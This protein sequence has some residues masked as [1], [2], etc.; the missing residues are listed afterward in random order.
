M[1]ILG[2][3]GAP[4]TRCNGHDALCT[5][6]YDEV[7]YA[8]THNA[9]SVK[10]T[11]AAANQT[12]TIETQLEE[13]IRGLMLDTHYDS[14]GVASYCHNVCGIGREPLVPGLEIIRRFLDKNPR[15]VVTLIFEAHISSADT[16]A[17]FEAC[18]LIRYVRRQPL[19]A[20]WPTLEEMIDADERLV[21]FTDA[22]FGDY[23]W[24]LEQFAYGF[25]NDYAAETAADFTCA[26]DRGEETNAI[27]IMNHFLT[28][29]IS[30][31][32]MAAMVN[33]Y[34]VLAPRVA[35]C[36]TE[37]GKR[38]NF[39][40]V[41]YYEIGDVLRVVDELN[42]VAASGVVITGP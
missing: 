31:E 34:E 8:T 1:A 40:T 27:F 14:S 15:E 35:Q 29:T 18:G 17:A 42:G 12:R 24:Y 10:G 6:R 26:A 9:F 25:Q 5:R 39:V 11:F 4:D 38:P 28:R 3:G 2:C 22:G 30:T 23:D 19:G 37:T 21:V 7:S 13:G 36:W 32:A 41:D 33:P 20:P 16:A